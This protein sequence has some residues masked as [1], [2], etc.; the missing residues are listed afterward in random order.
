VNPL[1]KK[2]VI[3]QSFLPYCFL[4]RMI[5]L[6]KMK[7]MEKKKKSGERR[8]GRKVKENPKSIIIKKYQTKK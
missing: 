8:N 1:A 4:F 7:K 5:L 6:A 3:V 2:V